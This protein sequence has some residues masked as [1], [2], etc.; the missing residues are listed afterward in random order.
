MAIH[1]S[2]K[3]IHDDMIK[4]LTTNSTSVS[5][6]TLSDRFTGKKIMVMGS[7]PSVSERNWSIVDV[8][9]ICTTSFFYLNDTIRALPNIAHVTLS[10]IVDLSDPRLLEF[11]DNNPDTTFAFEPNGLPFYSSSKYKAFTERYKERMVYYNTMFGRKEGVAGR[12]CYFL[13]SFAPAELYYVGI[14]GRSDNV[15][16]D[17][18]NVFRPHIGGPGGDPEGHKYHE[19]LT[20][21][22]DFSKNIYNES[23]NTNT[24]LYNLGEGLPFNMPSVHSKEHYPLPEQLLNKLQN[25]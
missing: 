1:S 20:S 2:R 22:I 16:N 19:C 18:V 14:D 4:F 3:T 25:S 15:F 13:M 9:M 24:R 21:Y 5:K 11:A 12:L 17:P 7:G 8:D 10:R 6:E 23:L